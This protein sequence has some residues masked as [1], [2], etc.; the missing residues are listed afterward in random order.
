M[1]VLL[2]IVTGM[3]VFRRV[4]FRHSD[5]V[6]SKSA[7]SSGKRLI[8]LHG[9]CLILSVTLFSDAEIICIS[10]PL[11]C[12]D[13]SC[14]N[15]LLKNRNRLIIFV[16]PDIVVKQAESSAGKGIRAIIIH[17]LLRHLPAGVPM[18]LQKLFLPVFLTVTASR[19]S[20][21]QESILV[22]KFYRL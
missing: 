4:K 19:L 10:Q 14:C 7:T 15:A 12:R 17:E 6:I 9:S 3:I 5:S 2:R 8:H 21:I 1:Y 13:L 18:H 16:F 11:F 20:S 22:T